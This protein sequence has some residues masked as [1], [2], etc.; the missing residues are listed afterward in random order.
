MA[1]SYIDHCIISAEHNLSAGLYKVSH[2]WWD[3]KD[4]L[5][6]KRYHDPK[7]KLFYLIRLKSWNEVSLI[8]CG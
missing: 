2:K 6:L 7:V 3:C 1:Q 5:K 4:D 8:F